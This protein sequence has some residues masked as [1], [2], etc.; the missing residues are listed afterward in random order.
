MFTGLA[1]FLCVIGTGVA[2]YRLARWVAESPVTPDP[3][4][5]EIAREINGPDAIEACPHCATPQSTTA[6]FC[7]HC[8]SAVG[9]Y[10]NLMPY[11]CL[12]S[13]GEVLRNGTTGKFRINVLTIAGY[14]L[15]SLVTY[16]IF[17]PLFWYRL[18]RNLRSQSAQ[19][20]QSAES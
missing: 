17:A 19:G 12:F 15:C 3:W 20:E 8:G 9:P 5:E 16:V 6:W 14:F 1:P 4:G 11:V 10:N 2:I 7:P 13:E 18:L